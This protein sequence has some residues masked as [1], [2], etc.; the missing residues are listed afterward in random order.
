MLSRLFA[1]IAIVSFVAAVA[2]PATGQSSDPLWSPVAGMSCHATPNGSVCSLPAQLPAIP[3]TPVFQLAR[4]AEAIAGV[5]VQPTPTSTPAAVFAQIEC[6]C[7]AWVY[8]YLPI[9]IHQ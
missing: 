7:P 3:I 8:W 2:L 9:E 5:V 4:I 1:V 6:P